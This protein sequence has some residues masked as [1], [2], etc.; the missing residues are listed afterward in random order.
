[1]IQQKGKDKLIDQ[2]CRLSE[3]INRPSRWEVEIKINLEYCLS[4]LI[5]QHIT[6]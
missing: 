1:M 5:Y 2:I 6:S 3:N 4:H